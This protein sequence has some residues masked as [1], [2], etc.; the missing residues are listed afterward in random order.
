MEMERILYATDFSD[1]SERALPHACR[2]AQLHGIELVMLHVFDI[3]TFWQH[4]D[5][6]EPMEMEMH[7]AEEA[8]RRLRVMFTRQAVH[9]MATFVA[10]ESTHVSKT[11]VSETLL[12]GAGLVV[13]G[14]HGAS[15]LKEALMGRNT[16]TLIR[17]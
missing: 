7:A 13:V 12:R 11:I 1:N 10:V 5:T 2:L 3:P 16:R 14:T 15:A 6:P 9:G 17:D 4:S 8:E